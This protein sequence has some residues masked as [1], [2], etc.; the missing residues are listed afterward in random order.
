MSSGASQVPDTAFSYGVGEGEYVFV[1]GGAVGFG[2]NE[3]EGAV[4]VDPVQRRRA[5]V[6]VVL[7]E[8]TEN[9]SVECAVM[10][11]GEGRLGLGG[12]VV[13]RGGRGVGADEGSGVAASVVPGCGRQ[14]LWHGGG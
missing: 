2:C 3:D 8:S 14:W 5:E 11:S 13:R 12:K 4:E 1:D 10:F 6:G 7:N 9:G